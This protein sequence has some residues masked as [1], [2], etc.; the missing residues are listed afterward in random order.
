MRAWVEISGFPLLSCF[1]SSQIQVS[2]YVCIPNPTNPNN[3]AQAPYPRN[4]VG[5][6]C[7]PTALPHVHVMSRQKQPVLKKKKGPISVELVWGNEA[8]GGGL[9]FFSLFSSSLFLII[10]LEIGASGFGVWWGG[11]RK[12]GEEEKLGLLALRT[13]WSEPL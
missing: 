3:A 1:P 7:L 9:N 13:W 5:Y 4:R 12:D 6:V 10:M 11:K 8:V 2:R